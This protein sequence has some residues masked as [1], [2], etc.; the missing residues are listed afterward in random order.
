MKNIIF[1][2][3]S[4]RLMMIEFFVMI[5]I[6]LLCSC[7]IRTVTFTPHG[8]KTIQYFKRS[9][10]KKYRVNTESHVLDTLRPVKIILIPNPKHHEK[11]RNTK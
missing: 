11:N 5:M 3:L 9:D 7:N 2:R 10:V 8:N 6:V 1:E 4:F